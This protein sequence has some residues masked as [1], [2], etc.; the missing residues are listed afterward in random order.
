MRKGAGAPPGEL[1]V[2]LVLAGE[3]S[4][5][6]R[7]LRA[8][9][10]LGLVCLVLAG[11][12]AGPIEVDAVVVALDPNEPTVSRIGALTYLGGLSLTSPHRD[13]GGL[14]GL[15]R[16]P[17]PGMLIAVSDRGLWLSFRYLRDA[18]GRLTGITEARLEPL[19]DER[20]R[21]V[22]GGAR[23]DAEAVERD[24][25]GGYVVSFERQHRLWRYRV[26][27]DP[28]RPPF[29]ARAQPLA[30]FGADVSLPANG[31]IEALAL[32]GAGSMLAVTEDASTPAGDLWGWVIEGASSRL[33]YAPTG[34]FKPT[35]FA[36]LP[37]GD[38]LANERRFTVLGGAGA[39]LQ[40]IERAAI[41]PGARIEG[42]EIARLA[43]PLTVDN[44]E[45][46]AVVPDRDGVLVFLL[47][48]DNYNPF[49]RTRLLLFRLAK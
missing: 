23:G 38:V 49:Q 37:S 18:D 36:L 5:I 48:D 1:G 7:Y 45:G 39:R 14:S 44:F 33:A 16:G 6:A 27:Q 9:L 42:S 47:S 28:S 24:P 12:R 15:A 19:L 25:D 29:A 2:G 4:A 43:P 26:G 40:I 20:G 41:A 21:P 35:D 17:V 8:T 10:G 31:G 46:L 13:F 3:R 30:S 34:L 32:L 22:A 11:A